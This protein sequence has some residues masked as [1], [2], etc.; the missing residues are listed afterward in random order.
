MT[1]KVASQWSVRQVGREM[2][3]PDTHRKLLI[4]LRRWGENQTRV[5]KGILGNEA[6]DTVAK[7]AAEKVRALDDHEKWLSGGGS[8]WARQRN[9][10]YLE[11]DGEGKVIGSAMK[12]RRKAVTN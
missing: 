6:A 9:K 12:W 5:G 11:G 8:E 3:D 1:S 4:R 2:P 10:A 7:N